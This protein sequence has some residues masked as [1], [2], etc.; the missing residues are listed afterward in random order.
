MALLAQ[1]LLRYL[2]FDG[3]VT[4]RD[5]GKERMCR[6]A[7]LKVDGSIFD[8]DNDIVV[9]L[10]IERFEELHAR[11]GTISFPVGLIQLVVDLYTQS[12]Q[13]IL[14]RSRRD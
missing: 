8:L 6:L 14:D 4:L 13:H 11:I 3:H 7:D 1:V 12:R 10:T 9:K 2:Q 5:V